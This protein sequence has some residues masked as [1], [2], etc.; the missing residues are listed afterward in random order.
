MVALVIVALNLSL[1]LV[2]SPSLTLLTDM[3]LF[4]MLGRYIITWLVFPGCSFFY[5]R[6]I[7]LAF[8]EGIAQSTLDT[9]RNLNSVLSSCSLG[10]IDLEQAE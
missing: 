10:D 1:R 9:L 3:F 8:M 2:L 5:K 6:R 4:Y 7:E